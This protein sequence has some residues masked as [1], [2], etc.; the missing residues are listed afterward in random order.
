MHLLALQRSP[1][2][3]EADIAH[4]IEGVV[5]EPSGDVEWCIAAR[6]NLRDQQVG[7]RFD[8]RLVLLQRG[9]AET[10]VPGFAPLVVVCAVAAGAEAAVG[11]VTRLAV[12]GC[13][14]A[15]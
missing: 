11:I 4:H 14:G 2:L 13:A 6:A 8:A 3:P 7:E 15:G 10:P 9:S 5:V 12:E 1:G